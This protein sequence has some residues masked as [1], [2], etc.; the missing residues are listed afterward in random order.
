MERGLVVFAREHK[1]EDREG[2]CAG[3]AILDPRTGSGVCRVTGGFNGGDPVKCLKDF[4]TDCKGTPCC[5]SP[6]GCGSSLDLMAQLW[7][8]AFK[9][10]VFSETLTQLFLD[11]PGLFHEPVK[12]L[13]AISNVLGRYRQQATL[14]SAFSSAVTDAL[15]LVGLVVLLTGLEVF[16]QALCL[17]LD[18][19]APLSLP[20]GGAVQ[21]AARNAFPSC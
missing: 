21:E 5:N 18:P 17:F 15:P 2:R 14:F 9:D 7:G 12:L 8:S 3:F 4:Q 6:S 1:M 19:A 11:V 13:N 20:P 16:N 10:S